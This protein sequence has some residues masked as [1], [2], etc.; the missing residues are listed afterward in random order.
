M[1]PVE[2]LLVLFGLAFELLARDGVQV[3]RVVEA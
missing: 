1:N 2:W 3:E